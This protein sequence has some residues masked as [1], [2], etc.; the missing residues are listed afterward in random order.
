MSGETPRAAKGGARWVLW[1]PFGLVALVGLLFAWG[2]G[3]GGESRLIASHWI[4]KPV[5]Q[6]T[7]P[8]AVQGLPG[9]SSAEMAAG[10]PRLVNVFAS[11]CIPCRAEAPQLEALRQRG[12]IIDGIAIRDRPADLARFL[13]E[14][15]NPYRAIG[16][17]ERSSVQIALGSSG[18]PETFLVDGHGM[19]RQQIQG[20]IEP[21]M[22]PGILDKLAEIR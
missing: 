16:A 18:V 4:D 20:V 8:P 3:H 1:L 22:I 14:T 17:D 10:Q 7:L 6:F 2:L 15:G 9:V 13:A 12:V 11:W 5:P 21:D 19:I